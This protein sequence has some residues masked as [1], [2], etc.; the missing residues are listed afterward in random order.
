MLTFARRSGCVK[1]ARGGESNVV[2]VEDSTQEYPEEIKD[3]SDEHPKKRGRKSLFGPEQ[4][5]YI[6]QWCEA[7]WGR[8]DDIGVPP[9]VTFRELL[10]EGADSGNLPRDATVDQ[11]RWVVRAYQKAKGWNP[12][13]SMEADN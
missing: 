5:G 3:T 9:N 6:I 8:I 11:L 4:Q 2:E 1:R 13:E 10:A 12:N 7:H